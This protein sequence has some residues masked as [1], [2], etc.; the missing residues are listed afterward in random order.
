MVG[1]ANWQD[2]GADMVDEDRDKRATS[3]MRA[4]S[5]AT[6]VALIA[7]VAVYGALVVGAVQARG[8]IWHDEAASILAATGH[9]DDWYRLEFEGAAPYGSW[10]PAAEYQALLNVDR[11]FDLQGVSR[12]LADHDF[13]PPFFYWLLHFALLADLPLLWAGP[14]INILAGGVLAVVAFLFVSRLVGST[15]AAL[16]ASAASLWSPAIVL[17]GAEAR[18]YVVLALMVVALGAVSAWIVALRDDG[19]GPS[20]AQLVAFAAVTTVGMLTHHQFLFFAVAAAAII[21]FAGY[22]RRWRSAA[23]IGGALIVGLAAATLLFPYLIPHSA[24]LQSI[25]PPIDLG[26]VPGRMSRW[27]TSTF[28]VVSLDL[29]LTGLFRLLSRLLVVS[30]L[31]AVVAMHRPIVRW[32]RRV[33]EQATVVVLSAVTMLI[34][35]VAYAFGRAPDHALGIKYVGALWPLAVVALVIVAVAIHPKGWIVVGISAG[36]ALLSTVQWIGDSGASGDSTARMLAEIAA[37]DAV[38][39]DCASRGYFPTIAQVLDPETP[40]YLATGRDL[41]AVIDDGW[42]VQPGTTYFL[43]GSCP[44]ADDVFGALTLAGVPEPMRVGSVERYEVWRW[45]G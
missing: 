26:E 13:H 3:A 43:H 9:Q 4:R 37:A 29:G 12:S 27:L 25:L 18:H 38:V 23:K 36:V 40:V 42:A 16:A 1:G 22:F 2:F 32:A 34:P 41:V 39:T 19:E 33:P 14:V 28:D 45:E 24:R 31:V 10:V 8:N 30:T 5:A 6:I 21:W 15:P 17:A 20:V 7:I 44:D 35:A 11:P